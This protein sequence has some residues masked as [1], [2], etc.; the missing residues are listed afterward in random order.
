MTT[1]LTTRPFSTLTGTD[2]SWYSAHI[3]YYEPDKDA[4][5]LDAIRPLLHQLRSVVQGAYFVR[6]WRQ[7]PHLRVHIRTDAHTWASTVTPLLEQ[8]IGAYLRAH[9]STA[10]LDE[11]VELPIHL[12]LAEREQEH[13]PLTPW[14]P[15]NSIHYQPYDPR[16]HVLRH[17]EVADLLNDYLSASTEILF[18]LLEY[19]RGGADTQELL[20]LGL[21]LATSYTLAPPLHRSFMSYRS[22]AEG[23]MSSSTDPA[24]TRAAFDAYYRTHREALT[25]RVRAVVATLEGRPEGP[26]VPF[27]RDWAALLTTYA[28][29]AKP[30]IEAGLVYPKTPA[31][32]PSDPPLPGYLQMLSLSRAYREGVLD[33][34]HFHRYRLGINW[35]YLQLNRLGMTP[36]QRM[37]TCYIVASA[38]ED[39]YGVSVMDMVRTFAERHSDHP[40]PAADGRAEWLS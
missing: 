22:H 30:L 36:F 21:M 11:R 2:T 14:Y 32:Q 3:Y 31:P 40:S 5:I 6:H 1:E 26:P 10:A 7:G 29:R 4:L 20:S 34:P 39:V 37:R 23:F 38:V 28:D 15:D 9:P 12:L 16:L 35:T 25:D 33:T 18:D 27:V 17:Q 8:T 24:A 19:I 13:G